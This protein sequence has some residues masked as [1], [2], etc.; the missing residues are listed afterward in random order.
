MK[1]SWK[2]LE[3]TVGDAKD[4]NE[5][6]HRNCSRLVVKVRGVQGEK[7]I[8]K[9]KSMAGVPSDNFQ[10]LQ[11]CQMWESIPNSNGNEKDKVEDS[12]RE[13]AKKTQ[14]VSECMEEMKMV[15]KARGL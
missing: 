1:M 13:P 2:V 3:Q 14:E 9:M 12:F 10:T 6:S 4:A 15:C 7:L 5:R 11:E 8:E